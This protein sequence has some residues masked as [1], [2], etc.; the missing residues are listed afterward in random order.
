MNTSPGLTQKLIENL[1]H[2]LQTGKIPSVLAHEEDFFLT[3]DFLIRGFAV[4]GEP[5]R[6]IKVDLMH[7]IVDRDEAL[8]PLIDG[9][10]AI[11]QTVILTGMDK[12]S[13]EA[14]RLVMELVTNRRDEHRE[15]I[16]E[17][18]QFVIVMRRKRDDAWLIQAEPMYVLPLLSSNWESE[19]HH[20]SVGK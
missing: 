9:T 1:R 12:A 19:K 8:Q 18:L 20:A 10:D 15:R 3:V 7:D 2:Q 16:P 11:H 13:D 6:V 17:K 14:N 4:E 5:A